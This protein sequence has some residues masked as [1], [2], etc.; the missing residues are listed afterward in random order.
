M[1]DVHQGVVDG[2]AAAD[3]AGQHLVARGVVSAKPVQ[4]QRAWP[5]IDVLNG[6]V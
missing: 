1:G 2:D 3:G 6:F 5:G 4:R